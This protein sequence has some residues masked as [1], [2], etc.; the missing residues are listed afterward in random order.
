[1]TPKSSRLCFAFCALITTI[2]AFAPAASAQTIELTLYTDIGGDED[3]VVAYGQV[4]DETDLSQW[5][6]QIYHYNYSSGMWAGTSQCS[7]STSG[8]GV[9]WWVIPLCFGDED[10]LDI[11]GL[12]VSFTCSS[13]GP[14]GG[15]PDSPPP[16]SIFRFSHNYNRSGATT[17]ARQADSNNR[18]CAPPQL[19]N[20]DLDAGVSWLHGSGLGIG[21]QSGVCLRVCRPGHTTVRGPETENPPTGTGS[22]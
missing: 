11:D 15:Y 8:S 6:G 4:Y 14:L 12:Y 1:M 3:V 18:V 19:A 22:C 20:V 10:E 5:G 9:G 16:S 21:S 13:A 17:A 7:N 2:A